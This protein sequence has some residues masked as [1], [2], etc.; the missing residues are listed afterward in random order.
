MEHLKDD[1][2]K[3]SDEPVDVIRKRAIQKAEDIVSS[4]FS[5]NP[6]ATIEKIKQLK[7]S[8]HKQKAAVDEHLKSLIYVQ[9]D[10]VRSAIDQLQIV[11]E[12]LHTV[13]TNVLQI[14][15]SV[16]KAVE[17]NQ[18][19]DDLRKESQAFRRLSLARKNIDYIFDVQDNVAKAKALLEEDKLLI[20]HKV[21]LD[22]ESSRNYLYFE[23]YKTGRYEGVKTSREDEKLFQIFFKDVGQLI[24][25]LRGRLKLLLSRF[26]ETGKQAPEKLVSAF[27]II[28]REE[29]LD[30]YWSTKST[31]TGFELT[32]RPRNFKALFLT[33]LDDFVF[34]RIEAASVEVENEERGKMWLVRHLELIRLNMVHDLKAIVDLSDRCFPPSYKIIQTFVRSYHESLSNHL[35]IVVESN[36]NSTEIFS[37]LQWVNQYRGKECLG[38]LKELGSNGLEEM[39]PPLGPLL[40]EMLLNNLTSTYVQSTADELSLWIKRCIVQEAKDWYDQKPLITTN[41]NYL[42]SYLPHTFEAMISQSLDVATTMGS[43]TTDKLLMVSLTKGMEFKNLLTAEVVKYV[44]RYFESVSNRSDM[45]GNFTKQMVANANNCEAF[46]LIL[47]IISKK[48]TSNGSDNEM[49]VDDH[50]QYMKHLAWKPAT[51]FACLVKEFTSLAEFCCQVLIR[52]IESDLNYLLVRLL[53]NEWLTDKDMIGSSDCIVDTCIATFDDYYHNE[54]SHLKRPLLHY[55]CYNLHLRILKYFLRGVLQ[56][57]QTQSSGIQHSAFGGILGRSTN[58]QLS[59]SSSFALLK[60]SDAVG[61]RKCANKLAEPYL[62]DVLKVIAE[63]LRGNDSDS[64]VLELASLH[65]KQPSLNLDQAT[66]ILVLRGDMTRNEA[67]SK[68]ESALGTNTVAVEGIFSKINVDE[69]IGKHPGSE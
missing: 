21:I 44:D 42:V 13:D 5:K 3:F 51:K 28:E 61:R 38:I 67:R 9:L 29:Y 64:I 17:I 26:L 47:S 41:E 43:V 62:F 63:I 18:G 12:K 50:H 52:E 14:N 24:V 11:K 46:P 55:L 58:I 31:E 23:M 48:F 8:A 20:A 57:Q 25:D 40:D 27:R 66:A 34:R 49:D 33:I 32:D 37:L 53:S 1:E 65:K 22:L 36:L 16:G 6:R 15:T 35:Q 69:P 30:K 45:R 68:A 4:K 59:G 56:C 54:Y 39:D 7:A 60:F 10:N 2:I 19:L